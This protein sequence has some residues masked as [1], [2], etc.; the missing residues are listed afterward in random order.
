MLR[1]IQSRNSEHS[2]RL[3]ASTLDPVFLDSKQVSLK[4]M[5]SK[6]PDMVV[7]Q[8][9]RTRTLDGVSL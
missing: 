5:G 9:P 1:Q 7:K 6:D 4:A 8:A 2:S 3:E